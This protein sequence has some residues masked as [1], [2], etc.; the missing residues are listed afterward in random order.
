MGITKPC[1]H[2]HPDSTT[3][4]QH[5]PAP[6][7][8]TQFH[9][10]PPSSFQPRPSSL[11]YPQCYWNQNIVRNWA[12]FRNFLKFRL[13][14]SK[15]SIL[16][17]DWQ[18]WYLGGADYESGLRFLKYQPQNSFLGKFGEKVKVVLF[19]WKLAHMVS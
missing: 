17:E 13:T 18:T 12:N 14:N 1:S 19:V 10:P 3:S 4:T 16:T 6:S 11:Q 15:L 9:P 8:S 5:P 7:T 2:H